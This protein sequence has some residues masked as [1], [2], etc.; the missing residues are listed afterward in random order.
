MAG[1]EFMWGLGMPFALFATMAPAYLREMGAPKVLIGIVATFP[2]LFAPLAI[3]GTYWVP[4]RLR[5]RVLRRTYLTVATTWLL[6]S[7]SAWLWGANWPNWL[8]YGLFT[9]SVAIFLGGCVGAGAIY[10]EMIT[11]CTPLK[12]RGR[13]FGFRTMALGVAG[14]SMGF[15]AI[16][17]LGHWPAPMNYRISFIIGTAFYLSSCLALWGVRDHINPAHTRDL[18]KVRPRLT[19]WLK[20]SFALV[21]HE[22]NYRI[23]LFF[24]TLLLLG[25][26]GAS[27]VIAASGD[28]LRASAKQLGWFSLVFLGATAATGWLMGMLADR[29]GYRLTGLVIALLM[30]SA[31]TII[32]LLPQLEY[33][34]IAYGAIAIS[35]IS[36]NMVLCNMGAEICPVVRPGRL[37]ALGNS[38]TLLAVVPGMAICGRVVDKTGTYKGVF[39][40]LL[41]LSIVAALGFACIVREPR[42]GRQYVIKPIAHP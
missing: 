24:Q 4:A 19:T 22:P 16:R 3:M 37:M 39:V 34:Y 32:L 27:L 17:L 33:W 31:Y 1:W 29:K 12:R 7:I 38:L 13:F 20:E 18:H 14:L 28:I 10:F 30:V 21:W 2:I 42:A 26:T 40:A 15:V 23:F 25:I 11:D 6:T 5:L 36:W 8:H 35:G 41:V 9:V